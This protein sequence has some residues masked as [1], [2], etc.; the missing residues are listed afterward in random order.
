MSSRVARSNN[1]ISTSARRVPIWVVWIKNKENDCEVWGI[2]LDE[3]MAETG[4]AALE[5]TTNAHA[6]KEIFIDTGWCNHLGAGDP[7]NEIL[8]WQAFRG[9]NFKLDKKLQA[10]IESGA[11]L[12]MLWMATFNKVEM[13]EDRRSFD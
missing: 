11:K 4:K 6:G 5:S 9:I 10:T 1:F 3:G 12:V 8:A 13:E 7:F 2:Y